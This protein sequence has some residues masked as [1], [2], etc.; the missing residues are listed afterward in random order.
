M[1]NLL[2]NAAKFSA[3]GSAI[4]VAAEKANGHVRV[5]VSDRGPGIPDEFK[6]RIFQKFSQADQSD[7]RA[8]GG[9]GLGLSISK[10]IVEQHGDAIGY[11]PRPG[12]GTTF[13][14]ELAAMEQEQHPQLKSCRRSRCGAA[15]LSNILA[16]L[17]AWVQ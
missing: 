10:A 4:E 7:T 9:S 15:R 16:E 12:G 14:F 13:A 1:S 17:R 8:K 2:S 11:D 3:P 6:D 5:S